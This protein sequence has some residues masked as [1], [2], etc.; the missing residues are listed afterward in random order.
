[1][2]VI[3]IA[4]PRR[5]PLVPPSGC[6]ALALG[7]RPFYLLGAGLAAL[8]VPLW[9]LLLGGL[10][11][12]DAGIS[13]LLWHGHE[14]I[15]GFAAAIIV[16]FLF[17]AGKNWT[18][19]ATPNGAPL[20]WLAALWLAGR[21]APFLLPAL[22]AALIDL[23]FLPV[24]AILLARVLIR[25]GSRRNYFI[26]VLLA[27]LTAANVLSHAGAQ[28]WFAVSPL[29]GLHLAIAMIATLCTAIAGRIVPSFTANALKTVPWRHARVDQLAIAGTVASLVLWALDGPA[30]LVGPLALVSSLL[31]AVRCNGW[32]PWAT[33]R[34][35]LLW[36]L[37]LSH[38]WLIVALLVLAGAS[39][40]LLPVSAVVHLLT[41]GLIS[42]LI[43]GMITRTTLGHT[44]RM[45]KAGRIE[46]ACYL[47]LQ[48]AL[49]LRVL[50]QFVLPQHYL[51]G[52]QLS[53]ACWALCFALY[54][55]KYAPILWRPRV[56][57]QEG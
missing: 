28:G 8:L 46:T 49:L 52:L 50:P 53:A 41:V 29:T 45:L 32:R 51:T 55:W 34:T 26:L 20:G 11:R 17:T 1:M 2:P 15:F 39:A 21:I 54:L 40:G 12:I 33:L 31:Q 22:P 18:G 27:V 19:L 36:I 23:A 3:P 24:A 57:G 44:G 9:I 14:M 42:G 56:D 38:G 43:L 13:P 35:P 10:L 5:K 48:A 7:F 4:E 25:A 47:L 6:A 30:I 37:H 16:G